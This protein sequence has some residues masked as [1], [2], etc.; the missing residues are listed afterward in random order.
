[1]SQTKQLP[2]TITTHIPVELPWMDSNSVQ[3]FT[4]RDL[5]DISLFMTEYSNQRNIPQLITT[6]NVVY[7]EYGN[8]Y[9]MGLTNMYRF[10]D[11][12]VE[13]FEFNVKKY[14]Q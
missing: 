8:G 13:E 1:M 9:V 14:S 5:L 4:L 3:Y 12:S 11:C 6:D 2:L 7:F 10:I